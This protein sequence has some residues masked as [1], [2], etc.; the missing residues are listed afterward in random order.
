VAKAAAAAGLEALAGKPGPTRDG[1]ICAAALCLRHLQRRDSL[2][3][4]ADAVR[5]VLDSGKALKRIQRL[6]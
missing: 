6:S 1:L 2:K 3:S 5:E 4:A